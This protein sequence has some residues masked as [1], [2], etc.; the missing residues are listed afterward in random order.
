MHGIY[1][2]CV[3]LSMAYRNI[4][5]KFEIMTSCDLL[6]VCSPASSIFAIV[7]HPDSHQQL[8]TPA[9]TWRSHSCQLLKRPKMRN[10]LCKNSR[11]LNPGRRTMIVA[12]PFLLASRYKTLQNTST[13]WQRW[14][15]QHVPHHVIRHISERTSHFWSTD[16][17]F[18]LISGYRPGRFW[19]WWESPR[20][21]M[22]FLSRWIYRLKGNCRNHF[23]SPTIFENHFEAPLWKEVFILFST[24]NGKATPPNSG[25]CGLT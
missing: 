21:L 1:D 25:L 19:K 7:Q 4:K 14:H 3:T 8:P 24:K 18:L 17:Q 12:V 2:S 6:H 22:G 5:K 13:A 9:T 23:D 10:S 11:I 16:G 15:V 20:Y